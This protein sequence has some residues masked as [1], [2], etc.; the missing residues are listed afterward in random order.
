MSLKE[1]D[2]RF[3]VL[4]NNI[5]SEQAPGLNVYEK[6]L[7][8]TKAQD[9]IVKNYFNR[10]GNKYTEGYGESIKR[11]ADFSK[12]MRVVE[13]SPAVH[14]GSEESIPR[15]DHRSKLYTTVDY[16]DIYFIIH[17]VVMIGKHEL[18]VVPVHYAEYNR[19]MSKPYKRP[20]KNQAWRLPNKGDSRYIELLLPFEDSSATM[21][22]TISYVKKPYPIILGELDEGMTIDGEIYDPDKECELDPI[23]HEEVLQRAVELAKIA[24]TTTGQENIQTVMQAG[25]RSE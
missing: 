16:D 19:L 10:K 15:I 21:T 1:F 18:Q 7:F 3:D 22:Y 24:W 8:L 23:L 9:E 13:L 14:G 12:L 4:F 2:E 5:A 6:S 17:E 20:L 25:Q 11:Q